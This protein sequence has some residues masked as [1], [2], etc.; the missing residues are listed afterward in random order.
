MSEAMAS[1]PIPRTTLGRTGI[2][3]TRLA[4]GTWGFGP[5]GP[6]LASVRDD[7]ETVAVLVALGA[8]A[9]P[10]AAAIVTV[11][12]FPE[13]GLT[14]PR[15]QLTVVAPEQVPCVDAAETS[16]TPAGSGSDTVAPA[17]ALGPALWTASV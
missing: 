16:V 15:S 14:V 17:A 12:S 5:R 1:P 10:V 6:A 4:L 7:E 9:G 3:T 11:T 8:A 2:E 13:P